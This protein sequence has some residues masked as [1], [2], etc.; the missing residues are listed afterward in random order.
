MK[1]GS[2]STAIGKPTPWAVMTPIVPAKVVRNWSSPS[3][4]IVFLNSG[5]S[6]AMVGAGNVIGGGDWAEDRLLPDFVRAVVE[7]QP[8]RIRNP[9]ATR[10][11]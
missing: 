7:D 9:H 3:F 4:A 8:I 10:P 5:V 6:L 1:T 11:W 2:G